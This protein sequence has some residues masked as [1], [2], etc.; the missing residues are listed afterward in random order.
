MT[1]YVT[2]NPDEV[3]VCEFIQTLLE[4]SISAISNTIYR[5]CFRITMVQ[6]E[7]EIPEDEAEPPKFII[8]GEIQRR[9]Q[10]F[11]AVRTQLT[12][13]VLSPHVGGDTDPVSHFVASVADLVGYA[14]R[15]CR[16]SDMV[17]ITIRN[18]VNLQD[19][20]IGIS[21]RRRDQLSENVIWSVFEKVVQSN[22]RFNALDNLIVEVHSIRIP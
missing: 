12:V 13:Q 8:E 22:A 6:R 10:R 7:F 21:F 5:V 9:H 15:N 3:C 17:G 4:V 20:A 2:S 11:N 18:E 1:S 16:D 19:R 14:V